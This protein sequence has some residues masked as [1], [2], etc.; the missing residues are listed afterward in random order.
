MREDVY[1]YIP[2]TFH[3]KKA[4]KDTEYLKF[5]DYYKKRAKV[6]EK[7]KKELAEEGRG[8]TRNIWIVKPG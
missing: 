4:M 2:L 5:L 8:K 7:E 3:I 1:Q 6:I